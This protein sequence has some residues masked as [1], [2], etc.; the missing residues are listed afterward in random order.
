M[1][2]S[3]RLAG[4]SADQALVSLSKL[5]TLPTE[6][7]SK[8]SIGLTLFNTSSTPVASLNYILQN[9]TAVAL[10]YEWWPTGVLAIC[11]RIVSKPDQLQLASYDWDTFRKALELL[12]ESGHQINFVAYAIA[13]DFPGFGAQCSG[14]GL[15]VV[16]GL[17]SSF[18][19]ACGRHF[20]A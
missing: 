18:L 10:V 11:S 12:V 19:G 2:S 4:E 5:P 13:V 6:W 1:E 8:I 7:R 20:R 9:E 17:E 3:A 15:R 16:F 14:F